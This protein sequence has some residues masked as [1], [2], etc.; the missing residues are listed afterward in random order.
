CFGLWLLVERDGGSLFRRVRSAT[1]FGGGFAAGISPFTLRNW[2]VSRKFVLLIASFVMLS[3]FLYPPE[4][5]IPSLMVSGRAPTLAE[6]LRQFADCWRQFPMRTLWTEIRKALF[7]LGL[8]QVGPAGLSVT[9]LFIVFPILF[10]LALWSGRVPR[11]LRNAI[12]VFG[13]SHLIALV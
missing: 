12:L 13:A 5:K 3:Y 4:A 11:S 7:T 1:I 2:M 9:P 6:S 8:T 10:A